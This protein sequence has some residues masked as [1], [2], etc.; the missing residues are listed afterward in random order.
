MRELTLLLRRGEVA[1]LGAL[2]AIATAIWCFVELAGEVIEGETARIDTALLM[3]FRSPSDPTQPIGPRWLVE[4]MRDFT[5]LGSFGVLGLVTAMAAGYLFVVAKWRAALVLLLSV[6]AGVTIS[7]I[8][9]D[10]I[11]RPR[12]DLSQTMVYVSSASFP[13]GHSMMSAVV[14]LTIGAM[15]ARMQT[16]LRAK[17]YIMSWAVL[18]TLL[19]GITRIYLGVHWPTDVL[20]GWIVG[21]A[22]AIFCWVVMRWVRG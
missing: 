5:A 19:V 18:L 10:V 17:Y 13:S 6:V 22:W 3:A 11:D 7:T 4:T 21:S 20:A 8:L 15:I 12:P 9:K 16:D 2:L 1:V 14:Y